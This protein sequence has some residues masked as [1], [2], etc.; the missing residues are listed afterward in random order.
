MSNLEGLTWYGDPTL[1]EIVLQNLISFMRYG[2]LEIGAFYNVTS[3]SLT[4][5]SFYG[6]G[7]SDYSRF[8]GLKNDWIWESD[9]TLKYT[10]GTQPTR[11]SG[12]FFNNAFVPTGSTILGTGFTID[13]S[14]GQVVFH[15]PLNSGYANSGIKAN[16]SIRMAHVYSQDEQEYRHIRNFLQSQPSGAFDQTPKGYLPAICV[17][18]DSLTTDRGIELGGRGK[19][20]NVGIQFDIIANN[21]YEVKKLADICYMMETKTFPL[22]N[23][24]TS[25]KPLNISGQLTSQANTWPNLVT[26]HLLGHARFEEDARMQRI[27]PAIPTNFRR[28]FISL[29]I[30]V[31][32]D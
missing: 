14:R 19:Y 23:I 13:Y 26:G 22:Y 17:A 27:N 29:Q 25:P 12:I 24:Q 1:E 2:L 3:G 9:I 18:V 32:P 5:Q 8:R 4:P 21:S 7:I 16:Y 30:P 20:T 15:N 31:F 6:S 11:P 28:V 10:G